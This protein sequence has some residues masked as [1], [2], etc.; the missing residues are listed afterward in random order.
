[1]T[2]SICV[3]SEGIWRL[4]PMIEAMMDCRLDYR[5]R[6]SRL[7][8]YDC[9]AG[10]GRRPASRPAMALA[11]SCGVP[12]V[13]FE[14]GFLRSVHPG[15][16]QRPFS[17]VMDRRGVHYDANSASDFEDCVEAAARDDSPATRSRAMA[18]MAGLRRLA[19]SK[20]NHAPLLGER[21]LGLKPRP[22]AG[23]VL[24]ID[25]TA[26]DGAVRYGMADERSFAAML[27]AARKENPGAQ[28]IVK[29]HPEAAAGAKRGYY[30]RLIDD[31]VTIICSLVNPWPLI[32]TADRVYAVTSL[33]GFE[34]LMAGRPVAC[35][36]AA[37]YAGWGLTDDR[38][39]IPRRR[40]RPTLEQLFAAAYL[41]Y[42]RYACPDRIE[43]IVFE[44]AVE[45]LAAKRDRATARGS[46]A[47]PFS[48]PF[49]G[50]GSA[51]ERW[52]P[53]PAA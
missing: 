29:S 48:L 21:A 1:M 27:A 10:W 37:F 7:T 38:A 33:L 24:V 5:P 13:S 50:L 16:G 46:R 32:E 51:G 31:G 41:R 47:A 22:A 20:Y 30:Q 15:G 26:G 39:P 44:E 3:L 25:Q 53:G 12:Y 43:P 4:R 18:G 40:A 45:L 9:V 19:L 42:A 8:G 6:L 2:L 14:D 34:A 23:R 36:G 49:K 35:F 28:I 52:R 17:L 11:E